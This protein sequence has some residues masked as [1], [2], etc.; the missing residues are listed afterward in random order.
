MGDGIF[1]S[2]WLTNG[3]VHSPACPRPGRLR[4][5][6]YSTC[7]GS[8]RPAAAGRGNRGQEELNT[9]TY[10]PEDLGAWLDA[11]N[12]E[13]TVYHMWDESVVWCERE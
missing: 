4:T 11:R 6:A 13:V 1:V 9:L 10:R 12:A 3:S 2:W 5:R 7:P 8:A